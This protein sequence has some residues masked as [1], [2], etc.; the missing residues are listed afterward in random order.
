MKAHRLF[1]A[2]TALVALSAGGCTSQAEAPG[3]TSMFRGD[4]EHAGVYPG[5]GIDG[6]AG[7]KWRFQTAGAVRSSPT[8]ADDVATFDDVV[9]SGS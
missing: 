2:T 7:V 4:P 6:F 3:E 1:S 8:V 9:L 5:G